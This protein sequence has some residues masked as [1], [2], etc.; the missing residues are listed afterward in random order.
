M[1]LSFVIPAY[2]E[3]KYIGRC[4]ESIGKATRGKGFDMEVI[5]VNNASSDR[6]REV[7]AAFPWVR[8]VDETEKGLVRAR[9][10]GYLA[11]SGD[12]IANVDADTRLPDDW[13]E[14]VLREFS[15][16][17]KLVAF[18]GPYL[19]YDLSG[20]MRVWVRIWYVFGYVSH[21]FGRH[22]LRRGAV[23]QGGNFVLRRD[24]LEKAGGYDTKFDFWGEDSAMAS[25]MQR[26]GKVK[27]SFD[28]P[29]YTSAR[30]FKKEG[31]LVT[32]WRYA[33][34]HAWTTFFGRPFTREANDIRE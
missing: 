16:N 7:A 5:V 21:L 22:V 24:A 27:F 25:R 17:D 3:E 19:Y 6:T 2:N 15:E 29:M 4:L 10:A 1:K 9:R 13:V 33:L 28:L 18:S 26:I 8:V 11:S 20:G 34:N 14:K 12:L 30:R 31:M 23:L 32:G